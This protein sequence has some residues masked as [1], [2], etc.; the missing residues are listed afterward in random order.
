MNP[1]ASAPVQTSLWQDKIEEILD[2][3]A[4]I[5]LIDKSGNPNIDD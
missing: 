3:D 1:S 5:V 4:E 2:K